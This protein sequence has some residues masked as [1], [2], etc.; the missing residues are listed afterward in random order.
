MTEK[1]NKLKQHGNLTLLFAISMVAFVAQGH[2]C[3][4]PALASI[5]AAFPDV[6]ET[7][8]TLINTIPIF[9]SVP[10]SF[11]VGRIVGRKVSHKTLIMSG[12][13]ILFL[14]K[15]AA[16]RLDVPAYRNLGVALRSRK[17]ASLAVKRFLEAIES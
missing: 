4:T 10:T 15:V 1:D 12:L 16:R 8:L 13:S 7:T 3:I 6:S 2:S 11:L 5:G 17:T 14:Y 9:T